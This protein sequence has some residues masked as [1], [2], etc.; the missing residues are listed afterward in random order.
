MGRK[1]K[2]VGIK[3]DDPKLFGDWLQSA[4]YILKEKKKEL[5]KIQHDILL[6]TIEYRNIMESITT[7]KN[8]GERERRKLKQDFD[9]EMALKKRKI[10]E[11]AHRIEFG[12][13]EHGK[14]MEEL[15]T[16][17][18]KVFNLEDEKKKLSQERVEIEKLNISL[19]QLETKTKEKLEIADDKLHKAVIVN[20]N[21]NKEMQE[22]KLKESSLIALEDKLKT[23]REET[24][25]EKINVEKVRNE[26]APLMENYRKQE[27]S[28]SKEREKL[29]QSRL[30]LED[31]VA[32][33]RNLLSILD[34]EKRR[35]EIKKRDLAQK[36]EE[37]KRFALLGTKE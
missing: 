5:D 6:M 31:K 4:D 3:N 11:D 14:R 9:N 26:I 36:E 22:L 10:D 34:E 35:I 23:E 27:N 28:L 18:A 30:A 2:E 20:E 16:R 19:K 32:E 24:N 8:D 7:Q 15:Q 29:D 25:K 1:P 17:E 13:I 33:E 12:L 21:N 37:L